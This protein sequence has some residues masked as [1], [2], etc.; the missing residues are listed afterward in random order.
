MTDAVGAIFARMDEEEAGASRAMT[1]AEFINEYGFKGSREKSADHTLHEGFL[2]SGDA[3]LLPVPE[4]FDEIEEW[5][6]GSY[7]VIWASDGERAI[8]SYCE[9]DIYIDVH[10]TEESYR[11]D[12]DA[13]QKFYQ[14]H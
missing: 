11:A 13:K 8:I 1:L 6:D 14:S 9:G 3:Y 10:R 12:Y 2:F 4:D 7:R 5:A